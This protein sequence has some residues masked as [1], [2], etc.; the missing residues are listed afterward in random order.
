MKE[1]ASSASSISRDG[2]SDKEKVP[3]ALLH[4]LLYVLPFLFLLL[5][6]KEKVLAAF[7][8]VFASSFASLVPF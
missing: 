8:L 3:A 1:N 6:K 5:F 4:V 2:L 7:L